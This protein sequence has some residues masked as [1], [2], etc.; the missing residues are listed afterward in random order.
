MLRDVVDSCIASCAYCAVT[1]YQ[2][3]DIE[4]NAGTVEVLHRQLS[5]V[6]LK[7]ED[8]ER[9]V[10]QKQNVGHISLIKG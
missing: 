3:A 1:V 10:Q 4:K 7:L 2:L 9:L 5:D 6:K 8:S